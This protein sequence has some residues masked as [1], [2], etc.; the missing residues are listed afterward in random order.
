MPA[1]GL[2]TRHG[3]FRVRV[4]QTNLDP[5]TARRVL[6]QQ[7]QQ[8]VGMICAVAVQLKHLIAIGHDGKVGSGL[9]PLHAEHGLEE[10]NFDTDV[11]HQKIE[12]DAP[13]GTAK[14]VCIYGSKIHKVRVSDLFASVKFGG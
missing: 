4:I 9:M 13:Q 11:A 12:T 8:G 3:L 10:R 1:M 7:S 14:R 2:G 6:W 5:R